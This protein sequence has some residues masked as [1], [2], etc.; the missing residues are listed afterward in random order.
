MWKETETRV[1]EKLRHSDNDAIVLL[2]QAV[3]KEMLHSGL[4]VCL[5]KDFVKDAIHDVLMGLW[6]KRH[7]IDH[8]DS[9]KGY[10]FV[11]LRNTL[12]RRLTREKRYC[13]IDEAMPEDSFYEES[14]EE[15]LLKAEQDHVLR[16]QIASAMDKLTPRQ[17]EMI[18]MRYYDELSVAQIRDIT[19]METKTIYNTIYN[20]MK[21]LGS[22]LS[23]C[24]PD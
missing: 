6:A 4:R 13:C 16:K 24:L 14:A 10:L 5:D 3:Y 12:L 2:H 17:Y 23:V 19:N 9:L 15:L 11:S 18:R 22:V 21:V 8:I 1:R 7:S 20:A